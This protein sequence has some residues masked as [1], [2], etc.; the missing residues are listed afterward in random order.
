MSK[1]Q[2]KRL[3]VRNFKTTDAEGLLEYLAEPRANCFQDEKLNLIGDAIQNAIERSK[4]GLQ[5][6][7]FLNDINSLIG[8]FSVIA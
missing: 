2:T 1:F 3:T 7:V 5:F 8:N 6:A 4:D